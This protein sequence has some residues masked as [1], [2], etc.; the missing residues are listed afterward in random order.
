M[1]S[2]L[3]RG[4]HLAG[5][6]RWGGGSWLL[7][8]MRFCRTG[9]C[10]DALEEVTCFGRCGEAF[11]WV[12]LRLAIFDG[13][14]GGL[15][16]SRYPMFATLTLKSNVSSPTLANKREQVGC[17]CDEYVVIWLWSQ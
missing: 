14:L 4:L 6:G 7:L 3:L 10:F 16:P 12:L 5:P 15:V 9:R 2:F 1:N 8:G 11:V 17:G 13:V